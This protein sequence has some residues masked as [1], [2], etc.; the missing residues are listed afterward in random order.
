[1]LSETLVWLAAWL[2]LVVPPVQ[3]SSVLAGGTA[4]AAEAMTTTI[5]TMSAA[6]VANDRMR[7]IGN[8]LD[9]EGVTR[10][11]RPVD[12]RVQCEGLEG[13]AQLPRTPESR[14][15]TSGNSFSKY[16]GE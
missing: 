3:P 13:L 4:K 2:A 5:T 6:T 14:S 8:L 10:R 15:S 12:Q 7:F 1:M 16:L 9:R 11:P